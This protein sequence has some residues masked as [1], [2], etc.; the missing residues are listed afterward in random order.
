VRCVLMT[1]LGSE[2]H[3]SSL[4]LEGLTMNPLIACPVN[5]LLRWSR[6]WPG[7]DCRALLG[8]SVAMMMVMAALLLSPASAGAQPYTIRNLGT[9]CEPSSECGPAESRA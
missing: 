7:P 3:R 5:D 2:T 8:L 4:M 1:G 9:L 6:R